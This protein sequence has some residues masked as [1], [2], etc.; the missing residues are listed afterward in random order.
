MERISTNFG[1]FFHKVVDKAKNLCYYVYDHKVD[2]GDDMINALKGR[3]VER[4]GSMRA[5]A[6]VLGW[7]G[8]RTS[9]IVSGRQEPNAKDIK[10][11]A[12]A[13]GITDASDF[14]RVFFAESVHNVGAEDK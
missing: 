1:N 11:M 4:Y 9:D 8:R 6:A 3:V 7:S 14:M 10:R 2:G 12:D 5:F 13:L